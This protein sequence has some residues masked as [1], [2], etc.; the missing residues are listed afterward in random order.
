MSVPH[1]LTEQHVPFETIFHPPAYT[2]QKRARYLH[3]PGAQVVKSVLLAGPSGYVL[4]ILPATRHVDTEALAQALGG[5]VRLASEEEIAQLFCDCE[6]GVVAPFGTRYGL[7]TL[8]EESLAAETTLVLE[9]NAH[10][11][12]IRLRRE[13]FEQL[14][15]PRRLSF[16]RSLRTR[17]GS[18]HVE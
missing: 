6:W 4:A 9:V 7:P 18:R 2:A 8:L 16:A 3:T 12:A 1:F 10:A 11:E 13:D 17:S 15:Q 5:P 14:E